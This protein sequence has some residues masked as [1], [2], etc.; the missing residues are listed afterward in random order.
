MEFRVTKAI[1]IIKCKCGKQIR[2]GDYGFVPVI[3]KNGSPV[4][5]NAICRN[6]KNKIDNKKNK[7]IA[8]I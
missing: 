5:E 6:C 3:H 1:G 2:K 4:F 8:Q 7:E